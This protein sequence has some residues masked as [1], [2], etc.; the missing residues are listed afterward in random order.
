MN[1]K[2]R[3]QKRYNDIAKLKICYKVEEDD[4][5]PEDFE[6]MKYILEQVGIILKKNKDE[7]T[8]EVLESKYIRRNFR[9][10][11]RKTKTVQRKDNFKSY[12]YSDIIYMMNMMTDKEIMKKIGMPVISTYYRHKKEMMNSLYYKNIDKNKLD[13]LAYL[14]TVEDN[15]VF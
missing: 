7:L 8:I 3:N 14:E 12:R 11:G 15:E 5:K 1:K 4:N 6:K 13:D 9:N 2:E 10:A